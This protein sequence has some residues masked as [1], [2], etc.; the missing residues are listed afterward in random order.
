MP[1]YKD[2]QTLHHDK[3]YIT[4]S[5]QNTLIWEGT[6]KMQHRW[7]DSCTCGSKQSD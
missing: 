4:N 7:W 2:L 3:I 1:C 5:K 6:G